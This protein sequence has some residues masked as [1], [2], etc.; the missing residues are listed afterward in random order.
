VFVTASDGLSAILNGCQIHNLGGRDQMPGSGDDSVHTQTRDAAVG[1]HVQ[2]Q[3][4]EALC[5]FN[6]KIV[7]ARI[8]VTGTQESEG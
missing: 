2:A 8:F 3:V 4:G 6:G 5:G 7:V 1:K